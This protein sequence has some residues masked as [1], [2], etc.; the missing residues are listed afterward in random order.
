MQNVGNIQKIMLD[1]GF[2]ASNKFNNQY[3]QRNST[4]TVPKAKSI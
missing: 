3:I 4:V 1:D 2:M